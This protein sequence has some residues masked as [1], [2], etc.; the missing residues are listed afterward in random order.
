MKFQREWANM[1]D[2]TKDELIEHKVDKLADT[3][4]ESAVSRRIAVTL[5]SGTTRGIQAVVNEGVPNPIISR[6]LSGETKRRASDW[7][8]CS[9]P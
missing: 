5:L 7:K 9:S 3:E 2:A 1:M 4:T 8:L 6:V